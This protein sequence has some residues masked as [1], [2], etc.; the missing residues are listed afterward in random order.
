M[1]QIW[2]SQS[3]HFENFVSNLVVFNADNSVW[4]IAPL[5]VMLLPHGVVVL[6]LHK[7]FNHVIYI[8]LWILPSVLFPS[9]QIY[10]DIWFL[11]SWA[12]GFHLGG[13]MNG[14]VVFNALVIIADQVPLLNLTLSCI[15]FL[16]CF[17]WF[18]WSVLQHWR[19]LG[20]QCEWCLP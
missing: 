17:S 20:W 11:S 10:S 4:S 2:F 1:P 19:E 7:D 15:M 13:W 6:S 8:Y 9:R 3:V 5:A 12:A 18:L 14:V 16:S